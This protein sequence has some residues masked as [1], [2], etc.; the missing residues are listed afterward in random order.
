LPKVSVGITI[1][2]AGSVSRGRGSPATPAFERNLSQGTDGRSRPPK[3][4]NASFRVS[5][6]AANH[7]GSAK[8][9]PEAGHVKVSVSQ[10]DDNTNEQ[11]GTF[12]FGTR[13]EQGS[14]PD[15]SETPEFVCSQGKRQESGN[16]SEV[17]RMK[18]WEILGGT[19][20][21]KQVLASPNPGDTDTP[22]KPNS[23]TAKGPSS[24]SKQ[25]FTSPLPDTIKTPDPVNHHFANC[26]PSSDP[27]ESDSESP[28]VV[29]I[30][31]ASRSLGRKK[32]P[33]ASKQQSGSA[34]KPLSTLLSA[35]KQ[36]NADN[37]FTFVKKC[38]PT[39]VV[40]HA[41][42]DSGSLRT[43]RRSTR[44]AKAEVQ[45]IRYSDRFSD[46]TTQDEREGKLSSRKRPSENKGEK[47]TSISSLS[48]T[49][50]TAESCSRSPKRGRR[51]N[52]MANVAPRKMQ[53]LESLFA[54]TEK[55]GINKLSSPQKTSLMSEKIDSPPSLPRP[56][57]NLNVPENSDRSPNAHAAVE[58]NF[59]S[60][61]SRSA[62]PSPEPKMHCWDH[63]SSPEINGKLGEQVTSPWTGRFRGTPDDFASPTL[64]GNVNISQ[65]GGKGLDGNLYT[66]KYSKSV[67]RS[68]SSFL[69]SDPE[70]EPVVFFQI[71][72]VLIISC[73]RVILFVH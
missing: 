25:V 73:S 34:K 66:S 9:E 30:R 37:A 6:E 52:L 47:A 68:K 7:D 46:K 16:K 72:Y 4:D 58:N 40:K 22:D 57:E 35:P 49:R 23:Q 69:V 3:C 61:P 28:K 15:K 50:K 10:P 39:T 29:E 59:N 8:G 13:R 41:I 64:A 17:L 21:N 14:I 56:R 33:A 26:K 32:V 36:K 19:S 44:Q 2:R 67:D 12:S 43:L 31:P 54:E 55:N 70:S 45:K 24:G 71:Q 1:P 18:L 11:R 38:T 51:L 65:Q 20:Q 48:R 5:Q 42:G 62:N 60:Q 63:D 53:F 27:I